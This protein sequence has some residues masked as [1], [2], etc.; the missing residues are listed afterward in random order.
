MKRFDHFAE[1]IGAA[2][3]GVAHASLGRVIAHPV[4]TFGKDRDALNLGSGEAGGEHVG[5]EIAGNLWN[6]R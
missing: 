2:K 4:M 6:V 1:Q 5:V 3:I